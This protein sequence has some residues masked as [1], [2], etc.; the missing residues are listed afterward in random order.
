MALNFLWMNTKSFYKRENN[1]QNDFF[2]LF[3][4]SSVEAK[5]L[6]MTH[7][8]K[9]PDFIS[10]KEKTLRKFL[11]DDYEFVVFNDTRESQIHRAI[12]QTCR[13]LNIRCI[14]IPQ[15]IHRRPYLPRMPGEL[16][17]I[18]MI[19]LKTYKFGKTL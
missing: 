5:L 17:N 6:V 12:I 11:K 13:E 7:A 4:L 3:I 15:E 10:L 1:D 16:E 2:S 14:L 8:Y 9:R 18:K 19:L